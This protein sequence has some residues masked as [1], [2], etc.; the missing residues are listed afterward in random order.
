[1]KYLKDARVRC[2][3]NGAYVHAKYVVVDDNG[4]VEMGTTQQKMVTH[5]QNVVITWDVPTENKKAEPPARGDELS[6]PPKAGARLR[7]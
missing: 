4:V 1:M 3:W 7:L 6:G 5:V 2:L